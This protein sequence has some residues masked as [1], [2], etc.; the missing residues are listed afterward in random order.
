MDWEHISNFHFFSYDVIKLL[1]VIRHGF[2]SIGDE[3][4]LCCQFE[5]CQ[6]SDF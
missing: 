6:V 5:S 4:T 1:N 3:L 2:T